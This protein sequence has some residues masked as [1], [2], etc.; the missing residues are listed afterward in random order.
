[1]SLSPSPQND[2]EGY[3]AVQ[4][5]NVS[6]VFE[7]GTK[8]LEDVSLSI[9]RGSFTSLLGPSGCGKSTL[10]KIIAGLIAPSAGTL[11]TSFSGPGS[12]G[13][14]FQD[15]TLM[16]WAD[17][18]SNVMMPLDIIGLE[19]TE[20]ER[21]AAET[22]Q[23]VGLT[24]FA[25]VHPRALSGGMKMRASLARALV[26]K[27]GVLLLDE[28]FAALDEMTRNRLND[29]LIR[30]AADENLTVIFVTH[31]IFESVYL[32][33]RIVVMAPRPGRPIAEFNPAAPKGRG[34]DYR[35]STDYTAMCARVSAAVQTTMEGVL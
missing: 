12:I 29:D 24:D 27:P 32:S 10:L 22:L 4:L 30:I 7:G 35:L 5:R 25:G 17:V 23:L 1:M 13:Y 21:R 15:P 3:P 9:V 19:D 26:S 11:D 31:S 14:V 8:A 28:P 2:P 16:P 34:Q 18:K 20:K 6:K 33:D